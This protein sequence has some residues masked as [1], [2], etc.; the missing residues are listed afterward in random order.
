M[1]DTLR[2]MVRTE[3]V[4]KVGIEIRCLVHA[5]KT[6]FI[7]GTLQSDARLQLKDEGYVPDSLEWD[8]EECEWYAKFQ[9]LR[10]ATIDEI[11]AWHTLE[12]SKMPVTCLIC[13]THQ[14]KHTRAEKFL[15][16]KE[17]VFEVVKEGDAHDD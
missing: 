4:R 11:D 8:D 2:I 17:I 10:E 7:S 3:E 13:N 6:T 9:T 1:S 14:L 5:S 12:R 15:Q 16:D